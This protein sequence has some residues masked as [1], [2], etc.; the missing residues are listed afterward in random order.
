MNLVH[1]RIDETCAGRDRGMV[2][3]GIG[4]SHGGL[5]SSGVELLYLHRCEASHV[6]A[7]VRIRHLRVGSLMM[8]SRLV[9]VLRLGRVGLLDRTRVGMV[10]R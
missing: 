7:G 6:H 5:Y 10:H 1:G 2:R 8:R 3:V 4:T 9:L